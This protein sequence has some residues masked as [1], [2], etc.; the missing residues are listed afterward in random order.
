MKLTSKLLTAA[1]L[2]VSAQLASAVDIVITG[3]TAAR[4]TTHATLLADTF[5]AAPSYIWSG[6]TSFGSSTRSLFKGNI[7]GTPTNVLCSWSGSGTGI[8]TVAAQTGV[9]VIDP[10]TE[11]SSNE[12]VASPTYTTAAPQFAMS[13]VFQSSTAYTTPALVN[14]NA[15]VIEFVFITNPGGNAA[16]I[17]NMSEQ[18]MNKLYGSSNPVPLSYITGDANDSPESASPNP[19]AAYVFATGRDSGSGTR[20][21]ALAETGYGVSNAVNHWRLKDNLT[22]V[23]G[24][25]LWPDVTTGFTSKESL[26]STNLVGNGGYN[27]GGEIGRILALPSSSVSFHDSSDTT[28]S[29]GSPIGQVRLV[30]YLGVS[31]KKAGNEELTYCGTAYSSE[32]IRNGKYTFWAYEHLYDKGSLSTAEQSFKTAFSA[33]LANPSNYTAGSISAASMN[34]TRPG[35]DG[36]SVL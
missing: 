22:D 9:Q 32:N 15:F 27:S 20:I 13:D 28:W 31:D 35:G 18:L 29:S 1:A 21:T 4:S 14:T 19:G 16:G 3:S 24:L 11:I 6:S 23:T 30:S 17:T 25:M 10:A 34:V 2:L 5:D 26:S 7:N 8:Q 36:A 33:G 12:Y